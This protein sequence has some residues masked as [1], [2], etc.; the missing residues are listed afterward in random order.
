MTDVTKISARLDIHK[1]DLF[2]FIPCRDWLELDNPPDANMWRDGK[3]SIWA[4]FPADHLVGSNFRV[5]ALLAD[6]RQME[7]TGRGHGWVQDLVPVVFD[8]GVRMALENERN[9]KPKKR[10]DPKPPGPGFG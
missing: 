2:C 4:G 8:E 5:V 9:R 3:K 7:W 10:E 6:L 1:G